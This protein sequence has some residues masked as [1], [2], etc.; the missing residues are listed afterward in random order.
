MLGVEIRFEVEAA[1]R[2]GWCAASGA[3]AM[4]HTLDEVPAGAVTV[5]AIADGGAM[6]TGI[7]T[8]IG[9]DRTPPTPRMQIDRRVL[10]VEVGR[11]DAAEV[12]RRVADHQRRYR[13]SL[14]DLRQR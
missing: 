12:A 9:P 3:P 6:T 2:R 8:I 14:L 13:S 4:V 1:R 7:I 11:W 10:W 5:T